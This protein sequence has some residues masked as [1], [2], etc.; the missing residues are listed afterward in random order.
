MRPSGTLAVRNAAQR[1][2]FEHELKG[3][4]SDG[5]W[6]NAK[7]YDHWEPWCAA[8]VVVD[9]DNLGRDFYAQR[10]SYDF[11]GKRLLSVVGDRMLR[12]ARF[13]LA[14]GDLSY[15]ENDA[16]DFIST[17]D[18]NAGPRGWGEWKT[19]R[20]REALPIAERV[21]ARA[22]T[23]RRVREVAADAG[24]YDEKRMRKDLRDLQRIIKMW[25]DRG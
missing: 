6:E 11:G 24:L 9:P 15:E 22:G 10:S 13:A 3:Q 20:V 8:D 17:L 25:R 16:L 21:R 4:L 12:Y 18:L 23:D 1:A 14:Y 2:L 19:S 7:P 5:N